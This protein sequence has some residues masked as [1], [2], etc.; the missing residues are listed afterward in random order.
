MVGKSIAG[1]LFDPLLP[2]NSEND[3]H[4]GSDTD[5]VKVSV[6]KSGSESESKNS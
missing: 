6:D 4:A 5:S 2:E 3:E 1:I